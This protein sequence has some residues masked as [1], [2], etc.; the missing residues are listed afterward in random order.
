[1]IKRVCVPRADDLKAIVSHYGV[2]NQL[3]ILIEEMSE[4]TKEICKF[5]RGEYNL[6][7]ISE[8]IADVQI[9][10]NQIVMDYHLEQ[11]IIGFYH[12]KIDRQLERI[13]GE[14]Y[15]EN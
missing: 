15:D 8:E 4:L 12:K 2:Q 9:M 13:K 3:N 14:S 1:M 7:H 11:T 10:I 5:K 6:E